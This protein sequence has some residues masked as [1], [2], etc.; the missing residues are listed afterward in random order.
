M[1]ERCLTFDCHGDTLVGI[2]HEP[3][4]L[5]REIGVLFIV[6][7]PQYR[8]GSHRHYVLMARAFADA[9]YPAMRFDCRGMGDST[10]EPRSFE[11]I[12]ADITAALD[13]MSGE[14]PGLRGIIPFG[15]CDAASAA[16]MFCTRDPRV[17]GLMLANPWTR[18]DSGKAQA[19]VR[20]Y[21][22][23]RI[24]K[25]TFWS[26][27]LSGKVGLHTAL[28]GFLSSLW[29]ALRGGVFAGIPQ[30]FLDSM[31]TGIAEFGRPMLLLV[32]GRDLT[33]R[34]FDQWSRDVPQWATAVA[35][36]LVVRV[37]LPDADH[38]FSAGADLDEAVAAAL[39]WL[40]QRHVD[41]AG[42]RVPGVK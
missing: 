5:P 30:T 18:T 11:F 14:L 12:E 34:E 2:L 8:V 31:T 32:S 28:W 39:H 27:L 1:R 20:H 21:Y 25:R 41:S 10:G 29:H 7:G 9:G 24:L 23:D 38:T 26:R 17:A 6:G 42:I 4:R 35:R 16:L 40:D 36:S 13:A 19:M 33:A 37:D 15:L 3:D 22:L